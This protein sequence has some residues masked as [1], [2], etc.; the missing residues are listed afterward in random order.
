MNIQS[1]FT[2]Q[3]A[4][5]QYH[6]SKL[7]AVPDYSPKCHPELVGEEIQYT[8]GLVNIQ[9]RCPPTKKQGKNA[10]WNLVNECQNN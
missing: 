3:M 8:W 9:Y 2:N 6:A 1:G 10:F 7:V 4:F 5:L